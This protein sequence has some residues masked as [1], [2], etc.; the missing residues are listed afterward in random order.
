MLRDRFSK[1][2]AAM[3]A[4]DEWLVAEESYNPKKNLSWEAVFGL[5]NGR[6][7]SRA[8]HEEGDV[9]KTL[10]ANYIHGVFDRSEAFQRELVNTPDWT[11]LRP[12]FCC[13]PIGV[14][15]GCT[16]DYLRVLDMKH[17]LVAKHYICENDDGRHTLVETVKMLS[18]RHP[19][20]GMIRMY[21]TPL[22]YEGILEFENVIDATV[23]NFIDFPRF[24]VKHLKTIC[25]DSLDGQGCYVESL[26]RD[27]KLP[28]GTASVLRMH[29]SRQEN[30]LRSRSFRPYG[31]VACEFADAQLE[32]GETLVIDKFAAVATGRDSLGVRA[33]VKRELDALLVRGFEQEMSMHCSCMDEMWDAADLRIDGDAEMS[34]ALRFN[35]FHLMNT[36]DPID[37]TVSIGAK[38]MH[39]EEYGGHAFWDTELFDHPFYDYVFPNIARKLVEYRYHLLPQARRNAAA[40]GYKGAQYP[41]ESADTGEEECPSWTIEYDG[42]CYRCHVAEYEHHVTADVAYGLN[43][44]VEISGDDEFMRTKGLEILLETA[45]FWAS[46]MVYNT[47]MD[48]YEILQVTGP[49]EWHEPVDNNA[50]TNHMARWNILTALQHLKSLEKTH[51]D[52]ADALSKKIG[53]TQSECAAWLKKVDKLFLQAKEGLIEQF[54]GYFEIPDAVITQWDEKGMPLMPE[55]CINKYGMDRCIL[56]QADVVMLMYLLPHLYDEKTQRIN[57]DYYEPRT[58]HRSSLSPSIHCLVGLRVN[59]SKRAYAYLERSAYVD[60]QDNQRN[61]REGIHA[62]SAGGT[63]QC[64]TMGYCGMDVEP[65]GVLCFNPRLPE[66]W[67]SVTFSVNRDDQ[68]HRITVTHEGVTITSPERPMTYRVNGE[69][70]IS[71]VVHG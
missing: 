37:N 68:L 8:S 1:A 41:W 11:K 44:Y 18:R 65:D 43:R 20:V 23:T 57:F 62:A 60:L 31:E 67:N 58:L 27:F 40:N 53:L 25:V 36:P 28:I 66:N 56:K 45:R 63:W 71:E 22:D 15:S 32:K 19:R 34:H 12:F 59:D 24:R 69:T 52:E 47:E 64:V 70:F 51:P 48:R 54:D 55:S 13:E 21:L 10:P 4:E 3:L 7:G 49:D 50:F 30:A 42:S 5:T 9:R 6:M 2:V 14:E 61:T 38:L 35:I 46:R 29:T 17:G 39:G 16:Q 33:Q 26:T